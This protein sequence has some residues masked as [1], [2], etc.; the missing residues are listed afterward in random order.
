MGWKNKAKVLLV[1]PVNKGKPS[2]ENG[3]DVGSIAQLS[4]TMAETGTQQAVGLSVLKKAQEVQSSTATALL[5]ALPP[6]PAAPNLPA[7]LGNRIN[8]TA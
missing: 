3:M 4:T 1:P 2:L 8:T 7:H 6:V 5:A